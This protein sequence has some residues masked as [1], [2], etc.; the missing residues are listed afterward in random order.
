MLS[1][2]TKIYAVDYTISFTANGASTKVDSVM[3]QNITKGTTVNVLSGNTLMLTDTPNAVEKLSDYDENLSIYPN[4]AEG[5]YTLSFYA[6]KSG[7]TQINAYNLEGKKVSELVINLQEGKNS[8]KLSFS[9]GTY[10]IHVVGTGYSYTAKI[11]S[12][13]KLNK[14][15]IV[16][17]GLE[18]NKSSIQQKSKTSVVKMNY[19]A[20]DRLIFKGISGNYSTIITDVPTNDKVYTFNFVECRDADGNYYPIIAIGTQIWMGKDLQTS[21]YRNSD[22]VPNKSNYSNWGTLSTDG[23]S[24]YSIPSSNTSYNLYN[25]YAVNDKRYIAPI[26]WHIPTD[27]EWTILSDYLGG[28]NVSGNKLKETGNNHWVTSNAGATNETGFNAFA[29]GSRSIDGSTYDI[30]NIGYWWSSTEGS[31]NNSSWYRD[32][33]N[34]TGILNRGMYSKSGGMSVRCVKGDVPILTTVTISGIT[35]TTAISGGTITTDGDVSISQAGVCWSTDIHPTVNNSK[36]NDGISSGTFTSTLTNLIPETTYYVRAY[37]TNAIGTSY[38]TEISFVSSI[39]YSNYTYTLISEDYTTISSAVLKVAINANDSAEAK[40]IATNKL[41]MDT[42]AASKFIPLFLTGK[43]NNANEKSTANIYFN[44]N[45][46]Y[47]TTKIVIANKYTLITAD[48]DAMGTT[49]LTPGQYDDFTSTIDPAFYIPIWLKIN[50]PYAIKGNIKLIRYKYLGINHVITQNATVFQFNGTNWEIYNTTKETTEKFKLINKIWKY[51]DSNIF[52]EKFLKDFGSFNQV[53]VTGT[54]MLTWA[55]Y[56][57]GLVVG[58]A[59]NKGASETWLVSP[60]IDLKDRIH[61][62]LSFD[63][64]INYG[65]GLPVTDLAGVYISTNY[66]TDVTTATWEKLNFIY[67]TTYSWTFLNSGKIDLSAYINKK[68]TFGFKYVA[69]PPTCIAWEFTNVKLLDQ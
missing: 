50:N 65:I 68:I 48:Y 43:Y 39:N 7:R 42:I 5:K 2:T 24:F 49:S 33:T 52:N 30:G 22:A 31:T 63:H 15:S 34:L 46:P 40:A 21:T 3:V 55:P 54:Y 37:A 17:N 62:T 25:W 14:A 18:I 67:P 4:F 16:Y 26:G 44:F 28:D 12:L 59:Y 57:G 69:T 66:T 51:I 1:V 10:V 41:F 60:E 47:D 27:A 56:N 58:N 61:P 11:I 35:A 8:F 45:S 23:Y 32:I 13:A 20:G 36:T 29:G 53:I 9:Q 19:S 64:A 6:K 38:G